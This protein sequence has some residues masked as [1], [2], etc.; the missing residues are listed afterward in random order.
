MKEIPMKKM[1]AYG[2][3]VLLLSSA[4]L[5]AQVGSGT[6]GQGGITPSQ[7][8]ATQPPSN[9]GATDQGGSR[10]GPAG[11]DGATPDPSP[12][13]SAT[14]SR[15]DDSSPKS[16]DTRSGAKRDEKAGA[17]A[18]DDRGFVIEAAQGGVAEV[19]LGKLAGEK[20]SNA[21]VKQF[22]A[23]MVT[24]H[25]K[26]N[27]ELKALA[28]RRNITVPSGLGVEQKAT[29]DRLAKLSGEAFDRAYVQAMVDDHEKDV[30]AFRNEA[31]NGKDPEVKTW[32]SK[33]L[34]TLEEHLKLVQDLFQSLGR[35]AVGTSGASPR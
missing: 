17:A 34:F 11:R 15:P 2:T 29:R 22:A 24:D 19:E 30:A 14:E 26:A 9:G 1:F 20:A 6:S 27:D 21:R 8:G 5:F 18:S 35:G 12:A 13:G 4:P 23:R 16:G 3:A 32:A 25:G 7:G 10:Q 28:E 31:G 33:T